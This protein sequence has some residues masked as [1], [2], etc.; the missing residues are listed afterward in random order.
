MG[1]NYGHKLLLKWPM[2]QS[3]SPIMNATWTYSSNV[4]F[5]ARTRELKTLL[6]P[7]QF[8]HG[9]MFDSVLVS[10]ILQSLR[11]KKGLRNCKWRI[12]AKN[13]WLDSSPKNIKASKCIKTTK[14]TTKHKPTPWHALPSTARACP[15]RTKP[16]LSFHYF[17][18]FFK[19][20]PLLWISYFDIW[21]P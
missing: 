14:A 12:G 16:V 1:N 3:C 15:L 13:A 17:I 21:N 8:Q 20:P 11:D 7:E 19:G 2:I 4:N 9:P 10:V 6:L 5:T 18:L